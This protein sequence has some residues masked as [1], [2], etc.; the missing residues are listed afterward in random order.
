MDAAPAD[1]GPVDPVA[2][3]REIAYLLDR[4]RADSHR[5]KA[6]R[7][8]A[9]AV[10]GLTP[11]ER[12]RHGTADSWTTVPGIG[13]RTATVV[14]QALTGA[15]PDTLATLRREKKPLTKGGT[16][17][18]NALRGDLHVHTT[19]SDGGASLEEMVLAERALG[20]EYVAITDHSPRLR[21]ARGLSAERLAEQL[22]VIDDLDGVLD[23]FRVLK[24][25]EVDILNDGSLDQTPEMLD[26]LDI[27]VSSVHSSLQME[28]EAMTHRMVAAIANPRTTILG[29]CTG[30]LIEGGRGTR[31]QSSFDAE[32]VFAAC[33]QFGVAVEINSRPE[34][35]DPPDDLLALAVDM[36]CLF[37]I[38]TDAHAPGQLEF[39]WYGAERAER[40]GLGPDRIVD[41]WPVDELLDWAKGRT[42]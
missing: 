31:G 37:S 17:L 27:V 33:A 7:R 2:A 14:R 32:V 25:I 40:A 30:R 10:A 24:G 11:E 18:W 42:R 19:W 6:Y 3:L 36:G 34:R 5:V 12:Q 35:L 13:P 26:L 22:T 39:G 15:V 41:C 1:A 38:D 8:A 16:T 4:S 20:R 23:G 28:K 9:D 21:V 29:H